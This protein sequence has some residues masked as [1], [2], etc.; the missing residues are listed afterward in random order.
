MDTRRRTHANSCLPPCH[1][2]TAQMRTGN[3]P[4]HIRTRQPL[5]RQLTR[6]SFRATFTPAP[7]PRFRFPQGEEMR[8]IY[9]CDVSRGREG[10]WG[11]F[12]TD[13]ITD[14]CIQRQTVSAYQQP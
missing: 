11:V 5:N 7:A 2:H 4:E 10:E 14:V 12:G 13:K 9:G 8:D 6:A 1:P 3:R